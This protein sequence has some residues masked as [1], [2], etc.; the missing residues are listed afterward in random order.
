MR[1]LF[2][3]PRPKTYDSNT[4]RDF[5]SGGTEKTVIFLGEAFQKLGHEVQWVTTPEQLNDFINFR[6]YEPDVVITQV[7]E[8]LQYFPHS[9]RVW[10]THHFSDQPIIQQ[11]AVYGRCYADQV[12]TLSQCHQQDFEKN[13]RIPSTTIGHG[14]WLDEVCRGLEKDPY[15]LIYASTPFRGLGKVPTLFRA[16]KEREPRATISICS[17]MATYGEPEKDKEYQAIF[18]EL[19]SIDG[20]ELKGSLNQAEL[21][22]EFA[23][24][25]IFFYP[26][27]GL[28]PTV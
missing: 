5:P 8:V 20:V 12:V 19:R 23:R 28:K 18:D 22:G 11:N 10:W 2:I 9:K 15:R 14:I 3:F 1:I 25:S 17:S 6:Q 16:I 7:A 4:V 13:L 21:Y 24:A 26:V 27:S